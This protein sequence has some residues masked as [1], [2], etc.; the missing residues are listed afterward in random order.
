MIG[1][2]LSPNSLAAWRTMNSAPT[3]LRTR[4]H[5]RIKAASKLVAL[6]AEARTTAR[7]MPATSAATSQAST[8]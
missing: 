8:T 4:K 1:V 2:T 3:M 7:P 6:D 5:S